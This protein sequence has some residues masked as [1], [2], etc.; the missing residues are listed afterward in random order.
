MPRLITAPPDTPMHPGYVDPFYED[1][2]YVQEWVTEPGPNFSQTALR[3]P[4]IHVPSALYVESLSPQLSFQE[5][6]MYRHRCWGPAPYVGEPFH[7]EWWVGV[8]DQSRQVASK[9]AHIV[10]EPYPYVWVG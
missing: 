4:L 3:I 5:I 1:R 6:V 9:E 10:Y 7:Y 8:D 2:P